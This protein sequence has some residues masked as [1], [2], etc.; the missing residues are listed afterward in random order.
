M[1]IIYFSDSYRGG[2]TTFLQ[3]N[4]LFNLKNKKKVIL[5]DKDPKQTFPNLK[6]HRC[7]KVFKL[8]IFK[9]SNQIK[10][11]IKKLNLTNQLFFFTNF[12]ILIYYFLF[13][14][15]FKDKKKTILSLAL[16]SGI[17]QYNLKTIVGLFLF[18]I[19]SL[20]LNYL[21]FG[22]N[23]SKKWWLNLFPWMKLITH[24]VI[25]NGVKK[26]TV[27]KKNLKKIQISFI[28]R[29]EKENDPELFINISQLNK[30]NKNMKFNIFGD[31]PLKK[32]IPK[33]RNNLKFW[34]WSKQSKIYSKTDITIITSPVNNF[35]YT[36]LESNSYGIPVISAA[37]GDI[38]KI[39]INNYN[40]YIFN[41]RIPLIFNHYINKTIKNYKNLSKNSIICAKKFSVNKSCSIIWNFLKI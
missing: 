35:P 24:K 27:K 11:S 40:G 23:S 7:L 32:K 12:A 13:F 25:F 41:K 17:F 10:K 16:H 33:N 14:L 18:S 3:Q 29:L 26:Q 8:N 20:R 28:G 30:N 38:R 5:F 39:I 9:D 36:A 1:T 2:N 6:K 37:R 31:G 19:F 4:I 22:S 15:S 34:G 21:I